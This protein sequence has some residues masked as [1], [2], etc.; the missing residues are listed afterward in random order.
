MNN[1]KV[2]ISL[3]IVILTMG[4]FVLTGCTRQYKFDDIK[5][6]AE[7]VIGLKGYAKDYTIKERYSE[8][9]DK[10]GYIDYHWYIKYKNIEFE[11]IDNTY[12]SNECVSNR[13][14][15]N[16]D[17]KVLD[18]FYSKYNNASKITY[19]IDSIYTKNTLMCDAADSQGVIDETKLRQGYDNIVDFLNTINFNE[20]PVKNISVAVTNG[21]KHVKWLSIYKDKHIKTFE[22]FK[23]GK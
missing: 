2:L 8:V 1:R 15:D 7:N 5:N 10:D 21:D 20:Y 16:F 23:S 22:E 13:L 9:K 19:K 14:E 17:S 6:Y 12:Y 3:I 4:L 11:I 18:Y